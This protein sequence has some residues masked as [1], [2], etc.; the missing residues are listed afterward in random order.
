MNVS[1]SSINYGWNRKV[2]T[3]VYSYKSLQTE[4]LEMHLKHIQQR[5]VPLKVWSLRNSRKQLDKHVV[6]CTTW[7]LSNTPENKWRCIHQLKQSLHN[8]QRSRFSWKLVPL[9]HNY[10]TILDDEPVTIEPFVD[11][12]KQN[13]LLLFFYYSPQSKGCFPLGV[14]ILSLQ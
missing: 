14:W 12:A 7:A 13:R 10:F 9:P 6:Q 11:G 4:D 5:S 1:I 8:V 2:L 3:F